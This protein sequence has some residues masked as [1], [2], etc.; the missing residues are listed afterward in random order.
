M[1]TAANQ[2]RPPFEAARQACKNLFSPQP[3]SLGLEP[4]PAS[5]PQKN[6]PSFLHPTREE[7]LDSTG[8][9]RLAKDARNGIRPLSDCLAWHKEKWQPALRVPAVVE[10][11]GPGRICKLPSPSGPLYGKELSAAH[12]TEDGRLRPLPWVRKNLHLTKTETFTEP[13]FLTTVAPLLTD[14]PVLGLAR[15]GDI[16][17]LQLTLA[18]HPANATIDANDRALLTP[19]RRRVELNTDTHLATAEVPHFSPPPGSAAHAWRK[20]GLIDA[21]G[22]PTT[23]GRIAARF[24][25]AEGLVIAAALEDTTYPIEEIIAH[26]ANIRGGH[27]FADHATGE[28]DRLAIATRAAYG[29]VDHEGYLEAGLPPAYGEGTADVLARFRTGGIR[30]L[31][32]DAMIRRGDIE[33]ATLEWHSLLRHVTHAPDPKSERFT[34]LQTAATETL[35]HLTTQPQ[36]PPPTL[37]A[38]YHQPR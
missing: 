1:E 5:A 25:A 13:E 17:A 24:Q 3:P 35:R 26:L 4:V 32:P 11:R 27:R 36:T 38:H 15:R 23:R 22:V 16:L 6:S 28:S 30:S 8:N 9:W 2:G 31:P 19:P 20:L 29:H 33:R 34:E 21:H 37:P 10:S 14:L 18:D 12:P 7:Y